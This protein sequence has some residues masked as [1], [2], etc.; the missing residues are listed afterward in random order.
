MV[1]KRGEGKQAEQPCPVWIKTGQQG[2]AMRLAKPSVVQRN[3][4]LA[5]QAPA[6]ASGGNR[7]TTHPRRR[8]Q[9]GRQPSPQPRR[10]RSRRSHSSSSSSSSGGS[11]TTRHKVARR[12]TGTR[13]RCLRNTRVQGRRPALPARA[14]KAR[15][16]AK[17]GK[18]QAQ[19][20]PC[21]LHTRATL[22]QTTPLQLVRPLRPRRPLRRVGRP[23]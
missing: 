9:Q 2:K 20:L 10:T 21:P 15:L 3:L 6:T 8:R 12:Q 19:A 4:A 22:R 23:V 13:N 17:K 1:P 5:M 7:G 14:S 16:Q 11:I 18:W